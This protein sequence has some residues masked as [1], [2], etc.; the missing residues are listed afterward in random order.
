MART[1]SLSLPSSTIRYSSRVS[2]DLRPTKSPGNRLSLYSMMGKRRGER[3]E[4][5]TALRGNGG[6][7]YDKTMRE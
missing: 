1:S 4:K 7:K 6:G 2:P 5:G 3:G